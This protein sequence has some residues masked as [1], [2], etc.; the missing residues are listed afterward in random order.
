MKAVSTQTPMK[1]LSIT[2]IPFI[3][4][5]ALAVSILKPLPGPT[6]LN[7]GLFFDPNPSVPTTIKD[8]LYTVVCRRWNLSVRRILIVKFCHIHSE[9]ATSAES[10]SSIIDSTI[11]TRIT[12]FYTT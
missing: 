4:A 12:G 10:T 8:V 3:D 7:S 5:V 2:L 11:V 6:F 9:I 1:L